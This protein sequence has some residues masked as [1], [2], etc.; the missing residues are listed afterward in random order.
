[1]SNERNRFWDKVIKGPGPS[2]CWIWTGAIGDDGYGRF[3]TTPEVGKQKMIRAH[4][5]ALGLVHGG[6]DAIADLEACHV[7]DNP[8]CV[9]AEAGSS[10]HVLL[11]TREANMTDRA[12]RG[13]HNLQFAA[14]FFRY[15]PPSQRGPRSRALRDLIREQG[16]D[17]QAIKAMMLGLSRG[18]GTLF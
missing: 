3:W 11:G 10:T 16:Y 1:M 2:D 8:I 15:Q 4:R 17:R 18:Q 13:R 12:T 5:Y 9:R 7:C 6:L 14:E